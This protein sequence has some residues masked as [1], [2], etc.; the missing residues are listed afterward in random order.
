MARI[1]VITSGKGGVGKTTVSANFGWALA[2]LKQKVL[3]VDA[4]LGLNNLDVVMGVEDKIQYD[5]IDVIE[6]KCRTK[7]AIL[8]DDKNE[9][10]YILPSYHTCSSY[11]IDAEKIIQ[12]LQEVEYMFDYILID[13]PA[14]VDEGFDRAVTCS[15]EAIVVTTPHISAIRDADKV[16]TLLYSY[17]LDKVHLVINRARG[18]LMCTGEMLDV[19]T[20]SNFLNI[21]LLGVIPE[22]DE[23]P[24]Q[25]LQGGMISKSQAKYAFDILAN[26]FHNGAEEIFDCTKKYKGLIGMVRRNIKRKI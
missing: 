17:H 2:N 16:I 12:V 14:G 24:T 6:G 4:D 10:L 15:H 11:K 23:V 25:L 26:N 7:Q 21:P 3:V 19:S 9:Y 1:V 22:D 20:I 8:Q 18:D 13:C 5:I